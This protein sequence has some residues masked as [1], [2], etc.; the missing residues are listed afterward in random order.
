M[1]AW[2]RPAGAAVSAPAE[3]RPGAGPWRRPGAGR[4]ALAGLL[5]LF[6]AVSLGTSFPS[7]VPVSSR[8]LGPGFPCFLRLQALE[9]PATLF[10]EDRSSFVPHPHRRVRSPGPKPGSLD[11]PGAAPEGVRLCARVQPRARGQ[12]RMAET[13][14]RPS[15]GRVSISHHSA[16]LRSS[17]NL[18]PFN[19][20][21]KRFFSFPR[22]IARKTP[23]G[24]GP[25]FMSFI[26][27]FFSPLA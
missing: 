14:C 10:L 8:P 9:R 15:R 17:R 11:P 7:A 23:Q 1:S 20:K 18:M 21:S 27:M 25:Y 12:D 4:A 6:L 19:H 26:G 2:G 13:T 5:L 22:R 24:A 16:S 3:A